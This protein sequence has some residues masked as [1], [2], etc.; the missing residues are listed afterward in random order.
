MSRKGRIRITNEL[1]ADWLG[2]PLV[3]ITS[4]RVNLECDAIEVYVR[5][6]EGLPEVPEGNVIPVIK[7]KV[8]LVFE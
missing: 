3:A 6:L 5:D 8:K 2:I 1:L 4:V 7:P